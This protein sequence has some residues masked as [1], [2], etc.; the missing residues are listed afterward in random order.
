MLEDSQQLHNRVITAIGNNSESNDHNQHKHSMNAKLIATAGKFAS[1]QNLGLSEEET[2]ALMS[3]EL[4]R[5][6]RK[7]DTVTMN[8]IERQFAQAGNSLADVSESAEIRGVSLREEPEVD[9]FGQDQ[10]DYYEYGP[11]D[12]Q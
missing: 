11:N 3:R 8:D 10:S 9:P 12:S 2:L 5:Q 1:G 6:K 4:R 7:D